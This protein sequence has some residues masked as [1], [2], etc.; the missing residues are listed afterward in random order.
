MDVTLILKESEVFEILD[1]LKYMRKYYVND[2]DDGDEYWKDRIATNNSI[3][4]SIISQCY[5]G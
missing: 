5:K 1:S 4:K 3:E 2:C